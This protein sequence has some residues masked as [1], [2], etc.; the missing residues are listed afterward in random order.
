MREQKEKTMAGWN[1]K[2]APG[3]KVISSWDKIGHRERDRKTIV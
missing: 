3:L 1:E 2:K